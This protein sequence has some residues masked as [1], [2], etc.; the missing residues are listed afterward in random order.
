MGQHLRV[1]VG[2]FAYA[3]PHILLAQITNSRVQGT[4][5]L[6]FWNEIYEA[7]LAPY[8]LYPTILALINPE[9]GKF[10]VGAKGRLVPKSYFR[11][12]DCHAVYLILLFFNF[13]GIILRHS[14]L[15][16]LG[17]RAPRHG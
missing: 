13:L 7:V 10:N 12:Q 2:I 3:A 16:I 15:F 11:P 8:I 4:A 17:Q 6:S 9:L 5:R 14:A 1:C